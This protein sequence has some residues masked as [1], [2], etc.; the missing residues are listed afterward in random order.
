MAVAPRRQR[1]QRRQHG[2]GSKWRQQLGG[3]VILAVAAGHLEVRRQHGGGSSNSKALVA[4][5]WHLLTII[6]M[7]MMTMIIDYSLFLCCGRG[8]RGG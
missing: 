2:D 6:A 3:S 4:A 8:G 7:V 5:A 1:W